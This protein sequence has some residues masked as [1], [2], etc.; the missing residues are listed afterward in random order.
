MELSIIGSGYVGTTIA[1]C[2]ADLGHDVVNVD[3]DDAIVDSLNAGQ[4]PI[5]EPGLDE[6]VE[7]H[8]GDR[9]RAT[10]DYDAVLDTDATF[11]ALPTPSNDDGSIDLSAMKAAASSLG[12]TLAQKDDAHLVVTKSTVVPTTTVEVIGPRIE[13]ASGKTVGEEFDIAMN[14]E[15]LREGT[16]VEDFLSPDKIVLGA[17]SERA[18]E[19]LDEIFA[20]LVERAGDPPVVKTGI[21]EAEMIKYANNAFLASK[22]SLAN[23]LANI[24]KEF[25][26]DSEEVLDAIGLDARI[27]SAFLGAG[28]GWGGSCFPK[29]T[30]AI[31]AAAR[32]RGYE[33]RLLQAAVD[34]NDE[35]PKRMLE[36]LEDRFD[37]EGKRVA[38][39]GLSFK[40]GTDDVRN[41]RAILLIDHLLDAGADVVGYDPVATENMRAHFP[42]ID[43]ATSAADALVDA[44][45]ALV[46]TDWDEFAALDAQFDEMRERVV[47]DGR[48]IVTRRDGLDYESLV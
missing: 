46:A 26:V 12:E 22:I 34:V 47:I 23:D 45:A 19:Q 43:Y 1:A 31:I 29:D 20:S 44:D 3:I 27:G 8:A 16:A 7:T 48:R 42:N 41:S 25:G 24:C 18:Y 38:V 14:P 5:H 9:L 11:L 13:E 32:A 40:P 33:P 17:Q 35:Q 2:F 21:S 30:A 36:L 37:P 10:T 6:L 28:L 15:F 4:A 39:L